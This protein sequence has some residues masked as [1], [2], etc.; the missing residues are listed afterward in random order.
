MH[1]GSTM[2]P[3]HAQ[4]C[5][6]HGTISQVAPCYAWGGR[7][8]LLHCS[9]LCIIHHGATGCCLPVCPEQPIVTQ[10]GRTLRVGGWVKTGRT[11]GGGDFAFLEL[12]DGSTFANLQVCE[13]CHCHIHQLLPG[14]SAILHVWT[15]RFQAARGLCT[16]VKGRLSA[17]RCAHLPLSHAQVLV[18][19][20][21][22]DG[23]EIVSGLKDVTATG[24]CV[25]VEGR[26]KQTPEGTLQVQAD[27]H[28]V[29]LVAVRPGPILG[30][31]VGH[32]AVQ[33]QNPSGPIL[34]RGAWL[35]AVNTNHEQLAD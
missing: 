35:H 30:R 27:L 9:P 10:V 1:A 33:H 22:V 18:K 11:A 5:C 14:T 16:M 20:E 34:Q 32:E 13:C 3:R 29:C 12:N 24:T 7:R 23:S 19:K 8:V 6:L 21:V 15:L 4:H 25:L 31:L 28:Q 26:L 2:T 17:A